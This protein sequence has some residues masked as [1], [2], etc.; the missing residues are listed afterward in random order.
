[1]HQL[2]RYIQ[3]KVAVAIIR[4]LL[5]WKQCLAAR[6]DIALGQDIGREKVSIRSRDL[7]RYIDGWLYYPPGYS[8][9]SPP[10]AK[11]PIL[12]N[13]HGSGYVVPSLGTDVAFCALVA[14]SLGIFV[15]DADYRKSPETPFPGAICDVEDVLAWIEGQGDD[16]ELTRVA[17]S[18]F[19]AGGA[20]A[21]VAA[22][23][24]K[25]SRTQSMLQIPVVVAMYP[26]TDLSIAAEAKTVPNPQKIIPAP[27]ARVI[28]D[29]YV[30]DLATRKDPRVS[31]GLANP[32]DFP[33]T[34]A[35]LTCS[36]DTLS[37]EA[38]ALASKL[39]DGKRKVVNITLEG[40]YHAFDKGCARETIEWKQ[41]ELAYS[42]AIKT[43]KEG[44]C[45]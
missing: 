4:F 12:V 16:F 14:R 19:S 42:L 26:P 29:C 6:R 38:N 45:L 9:A 3:L 8:A 30:P 40:V 22:S 23:V 37:P 13:W 41:R 35:I 20:L 17:V 33:D 11:L 43:I 27:V 21:L 25:K 32:H 24:L 31:P 44:L 15:L 7:K 10:A 36:G 2:F 28:C 5:G 34:V 1:M 18:G 39:H